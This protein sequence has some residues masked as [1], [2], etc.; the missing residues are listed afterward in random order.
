LVAVGAA[1][2]VIAVFVVSMLLIRGERPDVAEAPATTTQAPTETT[3]APEMTTM[4]STS[5]VTYVGDP[6]TPSQWSTIL[7]TTTAGEAPPAATCPDGSDPGVI[8]PADQPRPWGAA[9]SNQAGVFDRHAG[10]VLFVD[11]RGD[12]W[13]FDVCANTWQQLIVIPT[14]GESILVYDVD[15]DVTVAFAFDGSSVW[16]YDANTNTST[17]REIPAEYGRPEL[18]AIYDPVSGLV[19]LQT[20]TTGPVA[21]DVDSDTWTPLGQIFQ[22]P[23]DTYP[24]FL[25]GYVEE[26]DQLVF[27]ENGPQSGGLLVDPRT[28]ESVAFPWPE[29]GGFG[30]FGHMYYATSTN[31][32][33]IVDDVNGVC[34]LDATALEWDC[35]E[36]ADGPG[37]SG[38]GAG[39][40]AAIVG[41]PIN[42][43]VIL[44]YGYGPGFNGASH[45]EANALWAVDFVTGEWTQLLEQTGERTD[46]EAPGES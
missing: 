11:E 10:T 43:R 29:G 9:W 4:P 12:L 22:I 7:A 36:L 33:Y 38:S 18:G 15:S 1:A 19:V 45:Y 13:A 42:D 23:A 25:V 3:G 37:V 21:Y 24:P 44:I 39:F 5:T 26:T 6:I 20:F 41:D 17:R 16:A 35:V 31:T 27:M 14:P 46:E 34:R 8:G 40:L 2:A 28:G 30:G 32:P